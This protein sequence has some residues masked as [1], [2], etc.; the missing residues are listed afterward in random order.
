M[1][2]KCALLFELCTTSNYDIS[3]N[4]KELRL[5]K[6][7]TQAEAASLIGISRR[8]Y[9]EIELRNKVNTRAYKVAFDCL[10]EKTKIDEEHGI[11]TIDEIRKTCSEVFKKYDINF[12][13]LFGSYAKKYA[14]EKS[15]VD[16]L[17]DTTI[18]GIDYFG[19]IEELRESLGKVVDML[20]LRQLNNNEVLTRE[21]MKDGIKIYG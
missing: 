1:H 10:Y 6:N 20:S 4:I 8:G 16:L 21:I 17:V 15:D 18:T 3:M 14:T 5:S 19:I 7:L 2:K 12:C 11:L 13:Y 9:Q